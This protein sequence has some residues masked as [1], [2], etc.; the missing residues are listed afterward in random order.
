MD[1]VVTDGKS[2]VD[3]SMV[4]GEPIPVEKITES[5][6]SATVNGTGSSVDARREGGQRY[7]AG[8]D[9]AHGQRSAALTSA[10]T[11]TGGLSSPATS[12]PR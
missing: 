1:G 11:E 10:N 9:R 6:I 5:L 12:C 3:E 7:A 2:A 4:T 8:P